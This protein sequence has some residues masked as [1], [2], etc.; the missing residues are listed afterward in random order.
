MELYHQRRREAV[1]LLGNKCSLCEI[2]DYMVLTI[3]HI[4]DDPENDPFRTKPRRIQTK[5][6]E[7]VKWIID[8]PDNAIERLQVLCWNC[9]NLKR[10]YRNEYNKRMNSKV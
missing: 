9:N 3:D 4:N 2:N 5:A 10:Y 1:K 8:N 6:K 7:L